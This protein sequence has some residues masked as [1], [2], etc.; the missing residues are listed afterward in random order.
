M[1]FSFAFLEM[2]L[3]YNYV[4]NLD[5]WYSRFTMNER[6]LPRISNVDQVRWVGLAC[7]QSVRPSD[8]R[9][10]QFVA[11]TVPETPGG[12]TG[13]QGS[14]SKRNMYSYFEIHL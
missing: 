13:I 2:T 12:V 1:I 3:V 11:F 6:V 9:G 7:L 8:L 5:K 14:Y 10:K 4:E